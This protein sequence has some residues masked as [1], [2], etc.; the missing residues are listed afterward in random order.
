MVD[1]FKT[2]LVVELCL[3]DHTGP[4]LKRR[5]PLLDRHG[6]VVDHPELLRQV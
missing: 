1:R 4:R 3:L 6:P 2:I 5:R